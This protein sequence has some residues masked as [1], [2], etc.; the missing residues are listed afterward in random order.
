MGNK[1]IT[2]NNKSEK[3][4]LLGFALIPLLIHLYTNV[5]AGYGIFRDELYYLACSHRPGP[6][7]VDQPP[8]S[9]YLLAIIRTLIGDS[10]FAIRL[11]PAV[12]SSLTVLIAGLIVRKLKGGITATIIACVTIIV[13]PIYLAMNSYYSMN[14]IDIF[15]WALNAYVLILIFKDGKQKH[16]LTLGAVTGLG[17]LNKI[18]MAWFI[19]GL[20]AAL[21][22]TKQRKQLLSKWPYI[23][24]IVAAVL[25]LPFIIWNLTHDLAQL[26]FM[27]NAV[28]Y[29]YNGIS[30]LDFVLGQFLLMNPAAVPVWLAGLYYLF[31]DKKGKKF[32]ILGIIFIATFLILFINGH[33]KSEYLSPAYIPLIAAGGVQLEQLTRKKYLGWIRTAVPSLVSLIGIIVAPLA[34]PILPVKAFV[35]YSRTLRIQPPSSENK[36]LS[37]LPQFYADM[38]GWEN[39]AK[40]VS[41]VYASLPDEEKSKTVVF[42]RNYGEA[43]AV[44]YYGKKYNLPPVICPHNSY[45]FWSRDKVNKNH[46]VV[47]IVGGRREDHLNMYEQVD[48]A[49]EIKCKY[50]MPYENNL[51]VFICKNLKKPLIQL[52]EEEKIFI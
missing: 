51:P 33:S 5:F 17:L 48:R 45:W 27:R 20:V 11:L 49:A 34:L 22:I 16:W 29:K 40:T 24:G 46:A 38:F 52:W 39:L 4:L 43:G 3:F 9:I 30:R 2:L 50:C 15:F 44:E 13:T 14:S 12:L 47:I 25:F 37:E 10:V 18:S 1:K 32:N 21:I 31:M 35:P 8:F 23:A 19:F 36:E 26:E 7:Y 41:D 6:G 42:T 28:Q